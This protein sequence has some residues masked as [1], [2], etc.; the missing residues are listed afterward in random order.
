MGEVGSS[1]H[2]GPRFRRPPCDPGPWD[3]PSPVLPLA[4]RRSPSHTTRSFSAD[5]HTP[6]RS[7]VCFHGRSM[8]RRPDMSGSSWS[9]QVPRVPWHEHGVPSLIVVSWPTS[10]GATLLSSLLRTPAPILHP[11][12]ASGLPSDT[13]SLP[14]AVSPCWEEDL[15]D[16]LSAHLSLRAWTSTPGGSCGASTRCVPHDSGLPP[17]RTRSALHHAHTAT[18]VRRPLR[19]CSPFF[20]F[21]PTGLLTTQVAPPA[22]VSAVWQPWFLRPSL[23]W[24]VTSPR[25]GYANRLN[26]AIDGIGTFTLSDVQPCRLLP[27]RPR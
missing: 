2:H 6:L 25:P 5:S 16:V 19:G 4:S 15:P 21:R 3:F 10:A 26:R 13:Q 18:S 8:V 9:C 24:V 12:R 20:L 23:S 1:F 22:T 7:M 27:E 14:V 11:L 17:V